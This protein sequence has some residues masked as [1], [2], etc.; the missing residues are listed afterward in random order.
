M[1]TG[2]CPY[3]KDKFDVVE[4]GR[5][6]ACPK[7]NKG[8]DVFPDPVWID[9]RWGMVGVSASFLSLLSKNA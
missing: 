1:D 7:C 6:L 3:C 2:V 9:T 5:G 4:Y 8:I